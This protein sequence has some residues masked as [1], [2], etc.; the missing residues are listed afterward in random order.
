MGVEKET[1]FTLNYDKYNWEEH[2]HFITENCESAIDFGEG[3]KSIYA[4]SGTQILVQRDKEVQLAVNSFGKG[5]S[6]YLSGLPYS[7]ENCRLLHRI[8]LWSC[9]SEDKLKEWFSTNFNVDVHNYPDNKKY[10][11]VNNTDMAQKTTVYTFNGR[12]ENLELQP[13]EIKWIKY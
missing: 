6:V 11:I 9:N 1:G 5:R 7:L 8:I 10:C 3:K 13:N 12:N 4:L 2:P